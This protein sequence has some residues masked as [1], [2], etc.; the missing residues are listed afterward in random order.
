MPSSTD[1]GKTFGK[2]VM[3]ANYYD[4]P[5]CAT[6][7][8]GAR[9]GPRVRPGEGC[10]RELDLPGDEPRVGRGQ[11]ERP[12][13]G[14]GHVRFLH[15]R[16]LEREQRL[17]ADRVRRRRDQPLRRR[18]DAGA[19]NNKILVSV[20]NNGGSKFTGTTTDPRQMAVVNQAPAQQ[21]ADQFC[22]WAAF[23]QD[24]R[25]AVSYYDRQYGTDETTGYSDFSLSG[26]ATW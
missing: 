19:C 1:G 17:H 8:G 23:T 22:Q 9:P 7:Q 12:V 16:E 2:P 10:D 15:Q 6:Y 18:E 4:L 13:A 24:G 21:Y 14:R 20:S 5:D 25:L 26:R 11:P 3:V